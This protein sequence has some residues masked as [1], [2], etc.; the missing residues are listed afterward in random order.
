[1]S[2]P[3]NRDEVHA[4]T[5]DTQADHCAL[6]ERGRCIYKASQQVQVI[7]M[8]RK[9][10][11]GIHLPEFDPGQER[12]TGGAMAFDRNWGTTSTCRILFQATPLEK[13][14]FWQPMAVSAKLLMDVLF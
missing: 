4:A 12:M 11:F 10:L 7:N 5:G 9:M 1:M 13:E 2:H 6:E 14:N 8:C 3:A